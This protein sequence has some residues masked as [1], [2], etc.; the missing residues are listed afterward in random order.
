MPNPFPGPAT[1]TLPKLYR[2]LRDNAY[3]PAGTILC[4][5]PDQVNPLHHEEVH[6]DAHDSEERRV[7]L[8]T[9][10]DTVQYLNKWIV[11]LDAR[12]RH[13]DQ[14]FSE[15]AASVGALTKRVADLEASATPVQPPPPAP[16]PEP[17][18]DVLTEPVGKDPH[19][20]A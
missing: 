10:Q 16:P 13:A 12:A 2:M 1:G 8:L 4:L 9:L 7:M 3:Y 15:S 14:L 19:I 11:D 20:E 6:V 17:P 18:A 5:T